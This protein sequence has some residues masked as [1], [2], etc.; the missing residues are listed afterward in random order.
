MNIVIYNNEALL[1]LT[2]MSGN[3]LN[4]TA[5]ASSKDS[6]C[7]LAAL[8][9]RRLSSWYFSSS[10]SSC[11]T[12]SKMALPRS[13]S[14]S[15]LECLMASLFDP[16]LPRCFRLFAACFSASRINRKPSAHS[17][18]PCCVPVSNASLALNLFPSVKSAYPKLAWA[19]KTP[20][21]AAIAYHLAASRQLRSTPP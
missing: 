9:N 11:F 1:E 13:F 18:D 12:I 21:L 7:K 14:G 16:P 4:S 3:A 5:F 8:Y 20:L 19:D 10:F 17:R 6:G 2:F 15:L